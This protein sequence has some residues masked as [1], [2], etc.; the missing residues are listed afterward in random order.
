[1]HI[2]KLHSKAASSAGV[3]SMFSC[4]SPCF[5]VILPGSHLSRVLQVA[6]A[7]LNRVKNSEAADTG[8]DDADEVPCWV[9]ACWKLDQLPTFLRTLLLLPDYSAAKAWGLKGSQHVAE[10]GGRILIFRLWLIPAIPAESTHRFCQFFCLKLSF[11]WSKG[12]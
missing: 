8:E 1:M 7:V 5:L 2:N 11:F 3:E 9:C 6:T 10:I 12:I 4:W